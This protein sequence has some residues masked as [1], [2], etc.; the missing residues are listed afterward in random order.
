MSY[1]FPVMG[2]CRVTVTIS[3][4]KLLLRRRC[5]A[6]PLVNR[7]TVLGRPLALSEATRASDRARAVKGCGGQK[8]R[9]SVP[10]RSQRLDRLPA[11]QLVRGV[12]LSK[13]PEG[14]IMA[15]NP[16]GIGEYQ[17]IYELRTSTFH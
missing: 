1:S 9:V 2:R 11:A 14:A 15:H 8:R 17:M 5:E 12:A 7:E 13:T 10:R 3:V 16:A 6:N 4:N